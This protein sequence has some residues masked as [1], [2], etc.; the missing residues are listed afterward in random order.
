MHD[1][2]PV[3]L[4]HKLFDEM[5]PQHWW[6]AD[7]K[8]EIVIGA[9]LV[10]NTNWNNVDLALQNLRTVTGLDPKQILNLSAVRLQQLIRPSG[11][12]VNKT[13][14]LLSVLGWF[15]DHQYDFS[16]MVQQYGPKLR[17][18]LLNLT[19]IGEETADSLLVYVFDQ[20]AFIADKYA[21][22]LFQFLGCRHI[23]TY[24]KLQKRIRLPVD[25][26]YRDA[27]E[28]HG[29]ID[30]FGKLCKTRE[31]FQ[32]SFLNGFSLQQGLKSEIKK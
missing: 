13:K 8:M 5:G 17:H 32:K 15:N 7:T 22:N 20:P 23:E 30:E 1:I 21:R 18:Q 2:N 6:P 9:I 31:Q 11:F 4:Y 3:C 25:F 28:F 16:G 14:S 10:Q 12:Y 27:Q 24:S 26:D 29:L 19:G